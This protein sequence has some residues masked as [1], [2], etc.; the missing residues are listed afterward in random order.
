MLFFLGKATEII[1]NW[2]MKELNKG[3]HKSGSS[4]TC[5]IFPTKL[6]QG[7]VMDKAGIHPASHSIIIGTPRLFNIK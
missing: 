1:D 6:Q 3:L 2:F 7:Q 5:G 4:K